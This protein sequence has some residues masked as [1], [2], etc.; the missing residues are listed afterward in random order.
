MTLPSALGIVNPALKMDETKMSWPV[1]QGWLM[2]YRA[3]K[4]SHGIN[5]FKKLPLSKTSIYA[6]ILASKRF[7][8]E[9]EKT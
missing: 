4:E 5:T 7:E 2:A 1:Y 3:Q 9:E 6:C 8:R